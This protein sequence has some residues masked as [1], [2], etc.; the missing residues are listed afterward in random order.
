MYKVLLVD[1]EELERKVVAFTLQNSGL[2]IEITYEA[3]SGR[4]A[5]EQVRQT[6]PDLII[7]D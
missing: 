5:L 1:D 4:E 3:A 6:L 7:M 2:P